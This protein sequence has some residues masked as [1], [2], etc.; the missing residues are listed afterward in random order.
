MQSKSY[1][2]LFLTLTFIGFSFVAAFNYIVDPYRFFNAAD[3]PGINEYRQKFFLGQYV[4]KPYALREQAPEA[5]ILGVSRAGSSLATDHPG[6]GGTHVYNYAMAGST[7]YLLWRNYQHAK[8]SGDPKKVLLML[9]FYMFNVHKE[10]RPTAGHILRYEERLAVTPEFKKNRGYPVRLFKDTLTS[11]ISFEMLYE[12]WNTVLAQSKIASEELYKSTLTATGFWINDPPPNQT[13]RWLFRHVEKQYMTVTWYPRPEKKFAMRREDGSSNLIYLRKILADAHRGGVDVSIG[14]MPFHARLAE[15][16]RAVDVWD[17]FER[18]KKDVV[19]LVESEA[20]KAG[21]PAY[22]VWDF[23]GYNT[24]T[25]E[26]V[27]SAKDKTTRMKWH[28]DSTHVTRATGDLMQNILLGVDGERFDDFGEKVNSGNIG[29]YIERT[30]RSRERYV[31]AFPKDLQEV[32]EKAEQTSSW[33]K[34]A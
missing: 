28:L 20:T 29:S 11:L 8:A 4:S 23:T 13:Q 6:W 1:L 24:I 26:P 10:Q 9:D 32:L 18:W 5:V 14:F 22:P 15:A 31:E 16:M 33:R 17:D 25:M 30:R 12:S 19:R 27:P 3:R 2:A 7:A 21:Q 34:E